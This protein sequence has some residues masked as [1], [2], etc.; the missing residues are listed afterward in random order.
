MLVLLVVG[1]MNVGWMV[2]LSAI[3]YLEKILP[4]GL[5]LGRLAC[6]TLCGAGAIRLLS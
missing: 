5:A 3:I 2:A 1:V 4:R 6:L